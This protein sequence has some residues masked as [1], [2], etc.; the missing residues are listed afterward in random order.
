M[1]EK[2]LPE[3]VERSRRVFKPDA[4]FSPRTAK[5]ARRASGILVVGGVHGLGIG[6]SQR[7]DMLEVSFLDI[8]DI[9]HRVSAH[10]NQSDDKSSLDSNDAAAGAL[11]LGSLGVGALTLTS[12][13]AI[14]LRGAFHGLV[15]ITDLISNETVRKWAVPVLGAFTIGL[16]AYFILELPNT[17]PRNVGRRI[18]A[19]LVVG[20]EG[21]E[22]ELKFVNAHCSRVGKETRKVLRIASWDLR[23]RFRN[24]MDDRQR[25]VK[26]KEEQERT[27]LKAI[28]FF[29]DVASRAAEVNSIVH[30]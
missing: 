11:T 18:K 6:L 29:E 5:K 8:M 30:Q 20:E 14:G 3:D 7:P 12:G 23:E 2:Y 28:E 9:Q 22:E 4:M 27:A 21:Q 19:N 25:E 15:K 26:G 10:L 1:A 17:I 16:T 24:A 13:K